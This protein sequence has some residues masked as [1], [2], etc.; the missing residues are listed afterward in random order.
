MPKI[1]IECAS[2]VF[3]PMARTPDYIASIG[4]LKAYSRTSEKHAKACLAA[5]IV[6][7]AQEFELEKQNS[8]R[9]IIMT[10]DAENVFLLVEFRY[11]GWRWS[12]IRGGVNS[13]SCITSHTT[14]EETLKQARNHAEK[15]FSGIH[16]EC[17]I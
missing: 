5:K 12:V 2:E 14:I 1:A 9:V 15:S 17:R 13:G 10:R 7:S 6:A 11:G 16:W 4:E 8:S 3:D